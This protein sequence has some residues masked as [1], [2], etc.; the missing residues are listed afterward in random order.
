MSNRPSNQ[1]RDLKIIAA[2]QQYLSNVPSLQIAGTTF[3][4]AQLIALFQSQIDSAKNVGTQKEGWRT[5]V[6][7]DRAL[8]KKV[9]LVL[10]GLKAH[11]RNVFGADPTN[12]AALAFDALPRAPKV[13][14]QTKVEASGKRRA[15]RTARHTQGKRQ[16]ARIKGDPSTSTGVV[17][18]SATSGHANTGSGPTGAPTVPDA[19]AAPLA[20]SGPQAK[21]PNGQ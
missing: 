8:A 17:A 7:A 21:S 19:G 12:P 11:V 18:E 20:P 2:I 14:P 3:T 10:R 1:A 16:K 9:T 6:Q 13:S 15:T 4:P 5:V